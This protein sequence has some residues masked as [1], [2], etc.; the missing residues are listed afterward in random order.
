M[1]Y[2]LICN[3]RP[4]SVELRQKTRP[5]HLAYLA[6]LGDAVKLAGPFL[7]D[8]GDSV[9]TLMVIEAA[10]QSTAETIAADDPYKKAGLFASVEIRPWRWVL[11]NP[12][13]K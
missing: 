13:A 9:G 2:A 3:D 12:E 8:A 4:N 5:E 11:K 6:T 10:D 7:N 1:L